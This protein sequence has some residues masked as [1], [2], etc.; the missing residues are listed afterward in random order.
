MPAKTS[1]AI[2]LIFT[3]ALLL[4]SSASAANLDF[5]AETEIKTGHYSGLVFDQT[6]HSQ[7]FTGEITEIG[8]KVNDLPVKKLTLQEDNRRLDVVL[9]LKSCGFGSSS[10]T[11]KSTSVRSLF[12]TAS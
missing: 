5:T 10:G 12:Q 2:Q 6:S 7:S 9:T 11:L 8:F 4:S 1:A 3:A